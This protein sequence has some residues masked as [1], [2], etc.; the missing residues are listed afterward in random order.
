L[1]DSSSNSLRGRLGTLPGVTSVE[2][3]AAGL[4]VF[5]DGRGGLLPEIVSLTGDNLRDIAV[6]ETTL[7]SV[8]IKLTGRDLRD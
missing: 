7:E 8:F 1:Q 5:T 3:S 4:I 6:S 2:A